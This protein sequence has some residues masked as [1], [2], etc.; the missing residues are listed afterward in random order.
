M[1]AIGRALMAKPKLLLV[2]ELS[3]GLMPAMVDLCFAALLELRKQGLG[4]L[5][6]E[7][8]T[9]RALAVAD[10]VAVLVSGRIAYAA[11]GEQARKDP[12]MVDSFLGIR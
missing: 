12:A 10:Q 7:Q 6:V 4:V 3:L 11:D 9:H 2:D 8:N 5:L 1:L